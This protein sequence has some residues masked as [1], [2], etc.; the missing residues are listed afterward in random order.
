MSI[1]FKEYGKDSRA[2]M[3]EALG[4]GYT[5][6]KERFKKMSRDYEEFK[7]TRDMSRSRDKKNDRELRVEMAKK[8]EYIHRTFVVKPE[9]FNEDFI[10]EFLKS[11]EEEEEE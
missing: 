5:Y 4:H 9:K 10:R 1:I 3:F 7:K 8:L 6:N 11:L 2:S